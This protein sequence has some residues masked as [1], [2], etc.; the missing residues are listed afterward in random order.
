MQKNKTK[1]MEKKLKVLFSSLVNT[2]QF[3]AIAKSIDIPTRLILVRVLS[4]KS[5]N[6]VQIYFSAKEVSENYL[7]EIYKEGRFDWVFKQYNQ[8]KG[9]YPAFDTQRFKDTG[10][11]FMGKSFERNIGKEFYPIA[12]FIQKEYIKKYM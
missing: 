10:K 5:N 12:K 3:D 8:H 9:I 6:L 11:H 7:N 2:N 1:E 4:D